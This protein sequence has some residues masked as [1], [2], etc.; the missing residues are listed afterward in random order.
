MMALASEL[1]EMKQGQDTSSEKGR[2]SATDLL[3]GGE[4]STTSAGG[5]ACLDTDQ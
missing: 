1:R 3:V 2:I 5:G 4:V